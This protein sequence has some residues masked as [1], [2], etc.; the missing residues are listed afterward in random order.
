[1]SISFD[2]RMINCNT[3]GICRPEYTLTLVCV[4]LRLYIVSIDVEIAR[5][6]ICKGSSYVVPFKHLFLF[7]FLF[8]DF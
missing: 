6:M 5:N 2:V 1:M 8:E 7:V 4:E 3:Y